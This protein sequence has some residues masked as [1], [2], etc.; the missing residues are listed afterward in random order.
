MATIDITRQ[1]TMGREGAKQ[2]AENVAERLKEKI[3][4]NYRWEGDTL[5]F[6]RKGADGRIQV[7]DADVRVEVELGLL[8]RPMKG[9][10]TEKI[11]DYLSRYL[12]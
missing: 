12:T 4:V 11:N 1:H 2:A 3:D 5:R 8:L 10:I 7:R 6:Q 9:T